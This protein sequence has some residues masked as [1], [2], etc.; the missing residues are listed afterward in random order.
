MVLNLCTLPDNA[1]YLSQVLRKIS[2]MFSELETQTVQ[3]APG[4]SQFTKGHIFIKTV[5]GT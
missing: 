1:L 5:Y 3:M 4:W 2:K